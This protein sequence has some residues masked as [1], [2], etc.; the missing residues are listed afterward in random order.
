[1][2]ADHQDGAGAGGRRA[3]GLPRGGVAV[4]LE[5]DMVDKRFI[6]EVD[7]LSD[8]DDRPN[9]L[10]LNPYEFESLFQNLFAKMGLDTKQTRPR[11]GCR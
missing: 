9:L 5:F 4:D 1:V 2:R 6:D 7:V 3:E 10:R 8:L 11:A